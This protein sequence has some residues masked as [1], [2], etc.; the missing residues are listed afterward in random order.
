MPEDSKFL[1]ESLASARMAMDGVK[2]RKF[3]PY[4]VN[5]RPVLVET[6]L[7]LKFAPAQ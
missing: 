3:K 7:T 6:N 5:G 2:Q 4:I 1:A